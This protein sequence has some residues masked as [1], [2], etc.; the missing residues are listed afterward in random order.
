MQDRISTQRLTLR[1]IDPARDVD[2]FHALCA[3]LETTRMV[4]SFPHPFCR[5]H[6]EAR[7][8]VM[9]AQSAVMPARCFAIDAGRGL[10][11]TIG[12]SLG[13]DG[14]GVGY[15][16]SPQGRGRGLMTEALSALL[17]WIDARPDAGPVSACVFT[18]NAASARVLEKAGFT[19]SPDVS[20]G[21]S[22][23]RLAYHP[24]WTYRRAH[25]AAPIAA[26]E[27]AFA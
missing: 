25:C 1:P 10:I 4:G 13:A 20:R 24:T 26:A 16:M 8:F 7:I 11:G 22:M 14:W 9:N 6:A 19:R 17:A 12:A 27:T 21:W 2:A 5:F 15:M 3:D 23:A 18:D